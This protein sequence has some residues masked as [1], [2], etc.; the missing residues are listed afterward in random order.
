MLTELSLL[1]VSLAGL[2]F[3]GLGVACLVAPTKAQGFLLGFAGTAPAHYLELALRLAVGGA[4]VLRAPWMMF[5]Q[6]F[7]VFG[8]VL[9]VT[10]ACLLALPWR[11]HQRFAR[12]AVPQALRQLPLVAVASLGW[13]ALVLVSAAMG[14]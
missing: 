3:L 1:G 11:W 13:G 5:S 7:A 12:W 2:Y 9:I 4:F 14:R 8:W 6:T 10:S